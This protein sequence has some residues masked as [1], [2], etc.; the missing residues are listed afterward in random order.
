ML[1]TMVRIIDL[2]H[3]HE[4]SSLNSPELGLLFSEP[5]L[6]IGRRIN[7]T[8]IDDVCFAIDEAES[9][10]NMAAH[11]TDRNLTT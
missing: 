7:A 8:K 10:R 9:L 1:K 6:N 2:P 11:T 4:K 5:L 3:D